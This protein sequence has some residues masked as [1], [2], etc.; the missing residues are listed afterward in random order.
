MV[1]NKKYLENMKTNHL[2]VLKEEERI[3]LTVSYKANGF[4][5][6]CN[7]GYDSEKKLWFTGLANSN[8][9]ALVDLYGVN[10]A[11]SERMIQLLEEKLNN[12]TCRI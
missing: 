8:L 5:K 10:E 2:P 6:C 3:Y 9:K 12:R 1:K 11:T 4:A 7:C